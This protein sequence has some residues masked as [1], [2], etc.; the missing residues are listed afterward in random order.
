MGKP[1]SENSRA[2]PYLRKANNHYATQQV[3][4]FFTFAKSKN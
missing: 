1:L 3:A 4:F 2:I